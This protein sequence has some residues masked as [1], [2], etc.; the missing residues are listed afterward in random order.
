MQV[1]DSAASN[2]PDKQTFNRLGQNPAF[3]HLKSG[4]KHDSFS[5]VPTVSPS[6]S[7]HCAR[8]KKQ[9]LKQASADF[10]FSKEVLEQWGLPSLPYSQYNFDHIYN[11]ENIISKGTEFQARKAPK[12]SR[13]F[14][15]SLMDLPSLP[16]L[17]PITKGI[18]GPKK[19]KLRQSQKESSLGD[20]LARSFSCPASEIMESQSPILLPITDWRADPREP[21]LKSIEKETRGWENIVLKKLSKRT[22]RWIQNKKTLRATG[23]S[24]KWQNFLRHQYDWSHIRDELSSPSDL[25]LVTQLEAEEVAEFEGVDMGTSTEEGNKPELLLPEYYR[26]PAYLPIKKKSEM[27]VGTNKTVED[28]ITERSL[29]RVPPVQKFQQINPRAGKYAYSTD[30]VFEQEIYFDLVHIIHQSGIKDDE[31]V[32]ENLNHYCKHLPKAFP[33]GPEEW[34]YEPQPQ[35]VS[36]PTRGAF[37]W[38]ALPTPAKDLLQLSQETIGKTRRVKKDFSQ[39]VEKN[40]SWEIQVLRKMLQEWKNAWFLTIRWQ[41]A[42][43]EGLLRSLKNVQDEIKIEAIITCASAAVERPRFEVV[44]EDSD[45]EEIDSLPVDE[46]PKELQPL[47]KEALTHKKANVRMAAA[48]CQYAI[49]AHD[50]QAQNIMQ[51]ALAKGNDADS[52]AAAQCLALDGVASF[53]VVKRILFQLFYRKDKETE[54]QSC[55]LLSHLSNKTSM[56]HTLLAVELNSCQW[57]DRIVACRALSR[58]SGRSVNQDLK[59]KLVQLMWND[60]NWGVR[61]AAAQTLGRMKLGKEVHDKIRTMLGQGNSQ[62]RV[63]ALSLIG[64][65]KLMTAKLLPDFLNCFNDDFVAVR[66]EACLA[67]GALRIKDKMVY[68][69]LM[70]LVH[71][72]PYWKIKAFA[73]R[74]LGM[75][76]QVSPQLIDLLLWAIHYEDEPGVRLEACRSILALQLQ[77]DQIRDIFLDV[78][79]LENHEAVLREINTAMKILNLKD[80]GNQVMLQMI[81]KKISELNQKELITNKIMKIEEIAETIRQETKYI[82]RSRPQKDIPSHIVDFFKDAFQDS[83]VPFTL[84]ASDTCDMEKALAVSKNTAK[85]D[86]QGKGVETKTLLFSLRLNKKCLWGQRFLGDE[87]PLFEQHGH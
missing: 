12:F 21:W 46:I 37:R 71:S 66:R 69:S 68:D 50:S 20:A 39:K 3:Y 35:R 77:G 25:E 59:N 65:L 60:W 31:I 4:N 58:I 74:A 48:L 54:E 7:R 40:V 38:T 79:L 83:D 72:D 49:R 44:V 29:F 5:G 82:Y 36:R 45:S 62:D 1:P 78:L 86:E 63:D 41:D 52:W 80:R 2:S 27:T 19:Y 26:I 17:Q 23:P 18:Q 47:I 70:K 57:E 55:V 76:G 51:D 10:S 34:N 14:S 56:I 87:Q 22:A 53:A 73:I 11:T 9:Y 28:I 61:Q 13:Q 85:E 24:S 33:K 8:T 32:L 42:T 6:N 84:S 30:N 75:I 16:A 43:V 67:A 81:K 64:W 15:P